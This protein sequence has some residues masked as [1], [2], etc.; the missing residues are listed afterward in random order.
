MRVLCCGDRH[1]TDRQ[2]I[3]ERLSTLPI[4]T[5][6]VHGGAAGADTLAGEVAQEFSYAVEGHP[7]E[8][9]RY[10][11]AAGPIRNQEMLDSGIDL[12]LAFHS[13]LKQS[14]G[15]AD[16]VRRGR[17]NNVPVEVIE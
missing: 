3:R 15:T 8:W 11:R 16:M 7:A 1:W 2:K 9:S 17:K 5:T 10:R 13:N 4:G 6:I 14:R 12:I